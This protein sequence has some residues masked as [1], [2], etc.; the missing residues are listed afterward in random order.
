MCQVERAARHAR[1]YVCVCTLANMHVY[2]S[3]YLNT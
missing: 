2:L 1:V 3:V